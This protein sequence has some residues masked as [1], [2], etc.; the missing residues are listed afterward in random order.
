MMFRFEIDTYLLLLLLLP[1]LVWFAF[2]IIRQ[3]EALYKK[4]K[5]EEVL[6][7]LVIGGG[8]NNR[9]TKIYILLATVSLMILALSNPQLGKRSDHLKQ[10]STDI[11]L[12]LDISKSMDAIDVSPSRLIKAKKYLV[13]LIEKNKG[14]NFGI[15]LFAGSAYLQMPLTSD[16]AAAIMM[17][18][19]VNTSYAGSQGTNVESAFELIQRLN[20][21]SPNKNPVVLVVTDG[22]DH[23][24]SGTSAEKEIVTQGATVYCVA[25]G[26]TTGGYIPEENEYKKDEEGNVIVSKINVEFINEIAKTGKGKAFDVNDENSIDIITTDIENMLKSESTTKRITD[27]QSYFQWLLLMALFLLAYEYVSPYIKRKSHD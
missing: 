8:K 5:N 11:Y 13:D 2:Y 14:N 22:E 12:V 7:K 19:A 21:K 4:W 6:K 9:K 15:V 10:S 20:E 3:R 24:G 1:V 18:N 23:E 17:I 26:T 27:Y 16:Y 25:A